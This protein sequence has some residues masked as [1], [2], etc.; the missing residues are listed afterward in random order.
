MKLPFRVQMN[1]AFHVVYLHFTPDVDS[2]SFKSSPQSSPIK[3]PFTEQSLQSE[4]SQEETKTINKTKAKI[5]LT[6]FIFCGFI[7]YFSLI[8]TYM[9]QKYLCG[10]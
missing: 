2:A 9:E 1:S 8:L 7:K 6:V 10:T 5:D 4:S 3:S